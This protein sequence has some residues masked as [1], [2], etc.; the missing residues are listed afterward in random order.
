M[1]VA[2]L[3]GM[4]LAVAGAAHAQQAGADTALLVIDIQNFYFENGSLP[5]TGSVPA[6]AQAHRVL[7]AFRSRHLTVVH[8]RHVPK[9]A[10]LAAGEPVDPQYAIRPEVQPAPGEKIVTK[11]YA[12][13]FRDTD[14][15]AYLREKGIKRVVIVGMQTHMCVEAASRA[16]ADFG[17]DVVV[18]HEA[19]ATRPLT[20]GDRTVP[21]EMVHATALAAIDGTYGKVV[22]VEAFLK[23]M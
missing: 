8:V 21:A 9:S 17:F 4:L 13:S 6:A 10:K 3:A 22:G 7:E 15:L 12:N 14:L 19:C 5:L 18:L 16:A 23:G 2:I 1:K 20:F 11:Q